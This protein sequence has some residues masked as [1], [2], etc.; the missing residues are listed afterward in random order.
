MS[1]PP[2]PVLPATWISPFHRHLGPIVGMWVEGRA[3]AVVYSPVGQG[4]VGGKLWPSVNCECVQD[5]VGS[6][7]LSEYVGQATCPFGSGGHNWP[8]R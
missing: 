5:P 2:G 6:K 7:R 4:G 3:P 1:V 8:S